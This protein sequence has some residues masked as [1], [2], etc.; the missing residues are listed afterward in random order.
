MK[1]LTKALGIVGI[2]ALSFLPMKGFGQIWEG[3]YTPTDY[4]KLSKTQRDSLCFSLH[5][6]IDSLQNKRI[7]CYSEAYN[8][9]KKHQKHTND[10]DSCIKK[11]D[12]L[13]KDAGFYKKLKY[14]WLKREA[15]KT[16]NFGLKKD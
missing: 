6:E 7:S 3:H 12:S 2:T 9:M 14:D 5:T 13:E 10:N 4:S 11:A 1:N 8:Y 15:N 16:C